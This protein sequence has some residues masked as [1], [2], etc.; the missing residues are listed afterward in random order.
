MN[1]WACSRI[2]GLG[3]TLFLGGWHAPLA[4]LEWIPSYVW[5]FAKLLALIAGFIWVRGTLPRLRLDQLM[6]FAWKFMLPMALANIFAAGVW[7]FM[8]A[9]AARWIVCAMLVAAPYLILRAPAG[10]RQTT[11]QASVS[12]C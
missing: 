5:F 6:G 7:R 12:I 9:G 3:I 4:C 2:S 8:P 11:G 1:T 10:R